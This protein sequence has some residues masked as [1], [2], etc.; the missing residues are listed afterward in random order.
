MEPIDER[1]CVLE[2]TFKHRLE[3]DKSFK[4]FSKEIMDRE[5]KRNKR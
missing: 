4:E 3:N 5:K 1:S 2:D